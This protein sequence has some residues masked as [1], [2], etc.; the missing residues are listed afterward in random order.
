M[1]ILRE[2]AFSCVW[3]CVALAFAL[4]GISDR[5]LGDEGRASGRSGSWK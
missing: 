3:F 2:I 1:W 4:R 5:D